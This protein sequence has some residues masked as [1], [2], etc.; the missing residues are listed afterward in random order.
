MNGGY[1]IVRGGLRRLCDRD[2]RARA[3]SRPGMSRI[4]STARRSPP[5]ARAA[6][7]RWTPTG[8]SSPNIAAR[9]DGGGPS[10]GRH[11]MSANARAS[12]AGKP[13]DE[14]SR[15]R[16]YG[17][18]RRPHRRR[19]GVAVGSIWRERTYPFTRHAFLDCART[20][21]LRRG[22]GRLDAVAHPGAHRRSRLIGATPA[23]LK[24]ALAG[25]V[26]LRL[27]VGGGVLAGM[28]WSTTPSSVS[29][30]PFTPS[31]GP[32]LLVHPSARRPVRC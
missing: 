21:R 28:V 13:T 20:P 18:H 17:Q 25:G 12:N 14:G 16:V 3:S 1:I 27:V 4:T 8:T 2:E 5:P 11:S 19:A 30:I 29:A 22:A 9:P 26:R 15:S 10:S 32:R 6:W 24:A 31:T 7:P 23:Y